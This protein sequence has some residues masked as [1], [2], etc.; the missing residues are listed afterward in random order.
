MQPPHAQT[1]DLCPVSL[2][3]PNMAKIKASGPLDSRILD[4]LADA[5]FPPG[6][7][8]KYMPEKALTGLFT[9][10]VIIQAFSEDDDPDEQ[11]RSKTHVDEELIQFVLLSAKKLLAISILSGLESKRLHRLMKAFMKSK[12]TDSMLPITEKDILCPPWSQLPWSP[13]QL[14]NFQDSQWKF[15]VPVF[16]KDVVNMHIG[17]RSILPFRLINDKRF[18]GTFSDVWEVEIHAQHLEKPMRKVR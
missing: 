10:S 14:N 4:N 11:S 13:I 12:I 2:F 9:K 3:K 15:L 8:Q 17:N 16:R 6:W 1:P 18:E 7:P 5:N